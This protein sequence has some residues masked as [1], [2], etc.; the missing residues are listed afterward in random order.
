VEETL[1]KRHS[2]SPAATRPKMV[3]LCG[4]TGVGKTAAAVALAKGFNMENGT[5]LAYDSIFYPAAVMGF[6]KWKSS[7]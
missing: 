2:H 7:I 3:A 4:P 5:R 1:P 6:K